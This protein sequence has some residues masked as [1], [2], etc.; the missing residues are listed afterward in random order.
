[1]GLPVTLKLIQE[2]AL[3]TAIARGTY[4]FKASDRYIAN[5]TRRAGVQSSVRLHG[6]VDFTIPS[7]H[8]ERMNPIKKVYSIYP[9]RNIYN[10]DESDLFCRLRPRISHLSSSENRRDVR[11]TDLNRNKD[12]II[13]VMSVYTNGTHIFPVWDI[14]LAANQR[15][16]RGSR[17]AALKLFYSNQRNAW[18]NTREYSTW[19]QLWFDEVPN[20]TQEEIFL[21]MDNCG[22]Q[23]EVLNLR[24]LRVELL[25]PKP[26]HK[27]QPL[28]LGIIA[29]ARIRYRTI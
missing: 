17:Y 21:I 19:L 6:L 13:I 23:K 12:R 20:V 9:L 25:P 7:C 26:T 22:S 14:G 11:G 10:M 4:N 27:Y 2:R 28:D 29:N 16:F 8:G 18:M 15:C 5:F 1:M 3:T 24:G